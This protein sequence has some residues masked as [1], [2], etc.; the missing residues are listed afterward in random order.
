MRHH[1]DDELAGRVPPRLEDEDELARIC[2]ARFLAGIGDDLGADVRITPAKQK[3]RAGQPLR[4]DHRQRE[5]AANLVR[6]LAAG[7]VDV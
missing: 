6:P 5:A 4:R 3:S 7:F 2:T 1:D